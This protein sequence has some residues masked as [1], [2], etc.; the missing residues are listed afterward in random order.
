MQILD[1]SQH[2]IATKFSASIVD[3]ISEMKFDHK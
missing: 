1:Q 3:K 2:I